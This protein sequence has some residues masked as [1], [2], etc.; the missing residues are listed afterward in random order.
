MNTLRTA[1]TATA[2]APKGFMSSMAKGP[3]LRVAALATA[4]SALATGC[5][6]PGTSNLPNEGSMSDANVF[7]VGSYDGYNKFDLG[8]FEIQTLDVAVIPPIDVAVTTPDVPVVGTDAMV[9]VGADADTTDT[10]TMSDLG[11]VGS[12]AYIGAQL[13]PNNPT[14]GNC[15][16]QVKAVL[17]QPCPPNSAGIPMIYMWSAPDQQGNC[18][19]ECHKKQ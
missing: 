3:Q 7:D 12:D 13:D 15:S 2:E 18:Q 14:K 5:I 4:F 6:D 10:S 1:D 16:G 9:D 11:P 8:S 17:G 19:T